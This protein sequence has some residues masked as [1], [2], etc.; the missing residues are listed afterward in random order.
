MGG[1]GSWPLDD[2]SA[3]EAEVLAAVGEHRT[4]AQIAS[5][6][7]IS[8]RTVESH[9]SALL[10]KCGANDRRELAV[11]AMELE[12]QPELLEART[13][14]VGR[15]DELAAT[16]A[17]LDTGRLV[18]LTGPGGV[19]KTRLGVDGEEARTVPSLPLRSD[20]EALFLDRAHGVDRAFTAAPDLVTAACARL[21]GLPLAIELAAARAAAIGIDGLL[22][23]LED[24]LQAVIGARGG[25]NRH[26]SLRDV[27]RWSYDLL[28]PPEQALF[29]RLEV[30]AAGFDL[31]AAVAVSPA[32]PASTVAHLL[33]R[34]V[35]KSLVV[36]HAGHVTRWRLLET[37]RAFAA[38]QLTAGGTHARVERAHVEWASQVAAD[39]E[40]RLDGS[41][42]TARRS[43]RSSR[44]GSRCTAGTPPMPSGWCGTRSRVP[45]AVVPGVRERRRRRAGRGRRPTRREGPTRT[46]GRGMRLGGRLRGAGQGPSDRRSPRPGR[47]GDASAPGST[48]PPP[49]AGT[50]P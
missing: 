22:T 3:R 16:L 34:L 14:F 30:F 24:Q 21:D 46:R 4:N 25:A 11:L 33:G 5:R 35:E 12:A 13:S 9:V 48:W 19:G 31:D 18:T 47:S 2:I 7:H 26:H 39:L 49:R 17:A 36:R 45:A 23:A 8:V 27:L 32:D 37:V 29:C 1:V 28:E 10:R 44:P 38:E 6:L 40:T 20:A 50:P 42:W 43:R 41:D 15:A